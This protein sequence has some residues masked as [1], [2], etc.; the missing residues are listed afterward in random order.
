M[1]ILA[2]IFLAIGVNLFGYVIAFITG[3]HIGN[4]KE[5]ESMSLET[6]VKKLLE[7]GYTGT[8]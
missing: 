7:S 3:F 4:R 5:T 8:T 2:F 1:K 6:E